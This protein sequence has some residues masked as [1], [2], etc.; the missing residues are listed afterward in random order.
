M[1]R[2]LVINCPSVSE[3]TILNGYFCL[4]FFIKA[5]RSVPTFRLFCCLYKLQ[6]LLNKHKKFQMKVHRNKSIKKI[7]AFQI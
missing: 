6:G 5:V 4:D 3:R 7:K 2:F 1:K